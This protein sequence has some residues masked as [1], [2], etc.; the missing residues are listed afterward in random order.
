MKKAILGAA[1][2]GL[3]TFSTGCLGPNRAFNRV[4]EWNMEVTD[5]DVANELIFLGC[6][7]I[8]VYGVAYLV[9]IVVLNTIEYWSGEPA[10]GGDG[11]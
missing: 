9:D 2:A 8:P 5:S 7:I 11:M 3:A 4:H 10:M 1:L 6:T